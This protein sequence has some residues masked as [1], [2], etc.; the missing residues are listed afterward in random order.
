MTEKGRFRS[1]EEILRH[2]RGLE[3]CD[4][5]FAEPELSISISFQLS[6][7]NIKC[8]MME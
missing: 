7:V 4:E 6:E 8:G 2:F 5:H 1:N 3:R